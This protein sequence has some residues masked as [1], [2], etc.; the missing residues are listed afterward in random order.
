MSDITHN[1]TPLMNDWFEGWP[2]DNQHS[3]MLELVLACTKEDPEL[4]CLEQVYLQTLAAAVVQ[5]DWR[6]GRT[7][8]GIPVLAWMEMVIEGHHT[9]RARAIRWWT[10]LEHGHPDEEGPGEEARAPPPIPARPL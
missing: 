7:P 2:L 9:P 10:R 3:W 5:G 6:A 4:T 1:L 8:R